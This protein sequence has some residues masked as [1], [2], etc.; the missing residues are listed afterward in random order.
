MAEPP[1]HAV[2]VARMDGRIAYWDAG[3]E[4][5]FGYGPDEAVGAR[6]DLIVPEEYRGPHWQGFERV[7]GGGERRLDGAATNVPVRL[8]SGEV[9]AFP[10]RFVLL[11]DALDEVIGAMAIYRAR[12]GDEQPWGPVAES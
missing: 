7:M 1:T 11:R 5:F 12:R 9:T 8:R 3:A 6:V 10:A 4:H 2:V